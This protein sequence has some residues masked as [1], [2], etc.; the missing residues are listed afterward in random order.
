MPYPKSIATGKDAHLQYTLKHHPYPEMPACQP[1]ATIWFFITNLL[2]IA[3]KTC[4]D[5]KLRR[6]KGFIAATG[7]TLLWSM[8]QTLV[9]EVTGTSTVYRPAN[10]CITQDAVIWPC[11]GGYAPYR[12]KHQN[13]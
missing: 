10:A 9:F 5:P 11:L 4:A 12:P 6:S 8:V 7:N 1:F 3:T 2:I 13:H